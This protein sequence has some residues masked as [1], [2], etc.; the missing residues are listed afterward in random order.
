MLFILLYKALGA[1]GGHVDVGD[2]GVHSVSI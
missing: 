1:V 2:H